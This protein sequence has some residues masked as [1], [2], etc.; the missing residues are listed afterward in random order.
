MGVGPK[1]A[2]IEELLS[3]ISSF[4]TQADPD[5]DIVRHTHH[6]ENR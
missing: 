4:A 6:T 1:E 5:L 2:E 3:K